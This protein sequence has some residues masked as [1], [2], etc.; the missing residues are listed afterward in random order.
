MIETAKV[1]KEVTKHEVVSI[2]CNKCGEEM[3]TECSPKGKGIHVEYEAG[4][5][6]DIFGDGTI[7][8]FD[9]CEGCMSDLMDSFIAPAK[10]ENRYS[11][12]D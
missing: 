11:W 8:S 6:S 7:I 2:R 9:L 12:G 1:T 10:E 5:D 3:K 4:Y